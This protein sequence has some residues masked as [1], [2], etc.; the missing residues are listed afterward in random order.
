MF[1]IWTDRHIA[2]LRGPILSY[3]LVIYL[4]RSVNIYLYNY[5]QIHNYISTARSYIQ[6]RT[7]YNSFQYRTVTVFT[8]WP[9]YSNIFCILELT[10]Y[11]SETISNQKICFEEIYNYQQVKTT[12]ENYNYWG[13]LAANRQ[14]YI[15]PVT[16]SN[17]NRSTWNCK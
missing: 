8:S 5:R 4:E 6:Y 10:I 15:T 11:S 3:L 16:R 17:N 14:I 9:K 1:P 7:R 2:I 12:K 13:L